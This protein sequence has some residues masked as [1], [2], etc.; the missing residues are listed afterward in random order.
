MRLYGVQACI[1][2][3]TFT[4]QSGEKVD[5]GEASLALIKLPSATHGWENGQRFVA[6]QFE[7]APSH[8]EEIHLH[9]PDARHANIPPGYYMLFYVDCMGKPSVARMV[10]FDD[11]ARE[12]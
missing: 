3:T 7:A 2:G 11:Q 12:P 9:T 4:N 8:P 1:R 10:R 5:C 6:L